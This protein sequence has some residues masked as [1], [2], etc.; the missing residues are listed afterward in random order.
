MKGGVGRLAL[1]A[2]A[3][4]LPCVIINSPAYEKLS[5]WLPF[6]AVRYGLNY[7]NP[8]FLRKDIDRTAAA[9]QLEEELRLSMIQLYEELKEEMKKREAI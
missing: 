1:M 5:A 9:E 4:V 3:P 2:D 7:G 8:I 6:R